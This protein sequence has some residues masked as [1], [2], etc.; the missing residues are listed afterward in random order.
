[1][2]TSISKLRKLQLEHPVILT[3]GAFD[4]LHYGHARFLNFCKSL[5]KTLVVKVSS[6]ERVREMKGPDRP[7]NSEKSRAMLLDNLKSVDYVLISNHRCES[8]TVIRSL[9]PDILVLSTENKADKLKFLRN[10]LGKTELGRLRVKF[11][12]HFKKDCLSSTKLINKIRS[13]TS[14]RLQAY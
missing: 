5:G 9:R 1:M 12:P 8:S 10:E 3:G 4:I 2:L 6:D 14:E 7:V 11:V 13:R